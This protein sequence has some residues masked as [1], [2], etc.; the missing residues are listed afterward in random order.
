MTVARP[1]RGLRYD[2][3]KGDLSKV[4]IMRFDSS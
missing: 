2:A 4:I 1:F 3:D